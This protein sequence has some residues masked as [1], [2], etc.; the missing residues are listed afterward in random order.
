[1]P[2]VKP[3]NKPTTKPAE[4]PKT[5]LEKVKSTKAERAIVYPR[6]D[7]KV[8]VEGYEGPISVELAK[9]WL[10]WETEPEYTKRLMLEDPTRKEAKCK[11]GDDFLF[12]DIHKEKVR[13]WNNT[14]NRPFDEGHARSIG[15][16]ILNNNWQ[17]NLE[18][19]IISETGLVLS[20]QH[21]LIG[22][23]LA[24][25]EWDSTNLPGIKGYWQTVCP[26]RPTLQSTVAFGASEDPKVMRTFDN[27]KPRALSDTIYTSPIFANLDDTKRRVASKNMDAAVDV[28]YKRTKQADARSKYQTHCSSLDFLDKHPK[29]KMCVKHIV[30]KNKD[31]VISLLRISEGQ[32]TGM[33]YLM[34]ASATDSEA[35]HYAGSPKKE[36]QLDMTRYDKACEFWSNLVD[37]GNAEFAVLRETLVKLRDPF[38]GGMLPEKVKQMILSTAWNL[39]IKDETI[40]PEA[41]DV[42][43][44]LVYS[45]DREKTL[46]RTEPIVEGIDCGLV[47]GNGEEEEIIPEGEQLASVEEQEVEKLKIKKERA[48][49]MLDDA[50]SVQTDTTPTVEEED[51][52]DN[53][54]DVI[55]KTPIKKGTKPFSDEERAALVASM[56]KPAPRDENNKPIVELITPKP[57]DS[58][59]PFKKLRGGTN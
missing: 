23:I 26:K 4:T 7:I 53:E 58:K 41:L 59:V 35:Y 38:T 44:W 36:S 8:Y 17:V 57:K 51:E 15:Q 47:R 29:L 56:K 16:D 10:Y 19:I 39:F 43:Q 42:S 28:L 9:R 3:K 24:C 1:M 13:C 50:K 6:Y 48:E 46:I 27:V 37:Q 33:M 11:F 55:D 34:A 31:R 22:Y 54:D 21:R 5:P 25:E 30:D 20:G 32:S 52:D 49:K 40:T 2:S 18:N 14:K 45:D 12:K